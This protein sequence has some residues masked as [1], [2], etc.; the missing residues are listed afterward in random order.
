MAPQVL[1]I[2]QWYKIDNNISDA[3]REKK[4]F[5]NPYPVPIHCI[6]KEKKKVNFTQSMFNIWIFIIVYI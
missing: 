4:K 5:S 1:I 6:K 3:I 2:Q